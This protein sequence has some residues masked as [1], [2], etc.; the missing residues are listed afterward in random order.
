MDVNGLKKI[1]AICD[2][3]LVKKSVPYTYTDPAT[4]EEVS[5]N[6]EFHVKTLTLGDHMAMHK[7]INR[8]ADNAT[9]LIVA[10]VRVDGGK[11]KLSY[12]DAAGLDT[13]LA[14]LILAE[15][16]EVNQLGKKSSRL[17]KNSPMPLLQPESADEQ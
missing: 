11:Q 6:V 2:R 1:G 3:P 14:G 7:A 8:G 17:Q 16:E 5:E 12:N 13:N 9:A 10:A 15:I 4:G